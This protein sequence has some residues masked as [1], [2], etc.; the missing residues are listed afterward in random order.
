M[1]NALCLVPKGRQ[2]V[3]EV[4]DFARTCDTHPLFAR[5]L[6]AAGLLAVWQGDDS[7][8]LG[9]LEEAHAAAQ[10]L[11]DTKGIAYAPTFLGRVARDQGDD[12]RAVSLGMESVRLM[13]GLDDSWALGVAL[14]FLGFALEPKNLS[15]AERCF[16]ERR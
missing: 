12:A 15:A 11:R 4:L 2:H 14:T 6:L 16:E 13:R 8:A 7:A 9:H 5:G 3:A 10:R 1:R